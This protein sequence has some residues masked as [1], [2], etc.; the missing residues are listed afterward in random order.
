MKK[1]DLIRCIIC[2]NRKIQYCNNKNVCQTCYRK[3]LEEYSF[4]DYAVPKET[5][6]GNILKICELRIEEGKSNKEIA[7]ILSLNEVY[8]QQVVKKYTY[9]CNSNGDIR[10]I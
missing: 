7:E 3:I 5:L 10:P 8:V 9:R 2:K 6:K 1:G 4:R